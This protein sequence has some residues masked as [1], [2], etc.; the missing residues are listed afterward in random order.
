MFHPDAPG[1]MGRRVDHGNG[2]NV[3]MGIMLSGLLKGNMYLK[4]E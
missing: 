4:M 1:K 3:E 2:G